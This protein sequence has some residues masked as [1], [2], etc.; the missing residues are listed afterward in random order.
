MNFS[1]ESSIVSIQGQKQNYIAEKDQKQSRLKEVVGHKH[2]KP[3]SD[4]NAR[5]LRSNEPKHRPNQRPE[6][7][8][9]QF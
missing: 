9:F 4:R 6:L 7:Y 2:G 1:L 8:Q 3:S 5:L